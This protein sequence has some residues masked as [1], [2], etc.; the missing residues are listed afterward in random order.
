MKKCFLNGTLIVAGTNLPEFERDMSL[1]K[2]WKGREIERG[3]LLI[4]RGWF[5]GILIWDSRYL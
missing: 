2:I 1:Q 3:V 5:Y 4:Q